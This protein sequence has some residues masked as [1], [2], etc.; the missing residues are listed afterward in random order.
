MAFLVAP[1]SGHHTRPVRLPGILLLVALVCFSLHGSDAPLADWD[2]FD[3][4]V[5]SLYDGFLTAAPCYPPAPCRFITVG[6]PQPFS[7]A[8]F[9]G[10]T[11]TLAAQDL[12]GV[13]GWTLRVV[14]T[15]LAE[16][17]WVTFAGSIPVHT[18]AVP[19]SYDP[20]AWSRQAYGDP[21]AWVNGSELA[22]WYEHRARERM[23]AYFTLIP[24]D[25][26]AVFTAAMAAAY[27]HDGPH[28]SSGPVV[29]AD[30]NSIA[31]AAVIP[32]PGAIQL[33]IYAPEATVPVDIFGTDSLLTVDWALAGTVFA[34]H[35]FTPWTTPATEPA[36]FYTG[37]RLDIDSDGDGISDARERLLF[38]SNPHAWDSDGD[39]ASDFV[40]L[41][42]CGT[43]VWLRD[44]DGDGMPDGWEIANGLNPLVDDSLGDPDADGLTNL[45]EYRLGTNP[46]KI[47]SRI[48]SSSLALR[49]TTPERTKGQP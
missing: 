13:Q 26:F 9:P 11:N 7:P 8:G 27:A 20:L 41:Y 29:P 22:V 31:I 44:S 47:S 35:P 16:R 49:I 3:Q 24:T 1:V 19:P 4:T 15:Q 28:R 32:E 5:S 21:P 45:D 40:E 36:C 2:A 25:Q 46:F 38:G 48:A 42:R 6:Q 39:G 10:V 30:T 17:A 34:H 18:N 37:G 12:Q 14:E 23:V 33:W 43:D